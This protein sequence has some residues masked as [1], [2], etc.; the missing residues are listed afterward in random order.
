MIAWIVFYDDGSSFTSEDGAPERAPKDGVQIV[1]VRDI[2]TGVQWISGNDHYCWQGGTWVG[3]NRE[4]IRHYRIRCQ[5]KGEP[6]VILN[7]YG[8]PD[9]DWY[10]IANTAYSDP[11]L[12]AKS[13]IHPLEETPE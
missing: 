3:H 4:V 12:P 13:G 6:A 8:L 7:G 9:E 2:K 1:A 11:R 10:R 5:Q